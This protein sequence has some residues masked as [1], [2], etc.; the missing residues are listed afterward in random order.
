M[1]CTHSTICANRFIVYLHT[2]I[3]YPC[4]TH[5][6]IEWA[7]WIVFCSMCSFDN[8]SCLYIMY[9]SVC[10]L[11]SINMY[12]I[13]FI[14]NVVNKCVWCGASVWMCVCVCVF[15]VPFVNSTM[16]GKIVVSYVMWIAFR[17]LI[18]NIA[19]FVWLCM[20]I[21]VYVNPMRIEQ[22]CSLLCIW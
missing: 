5:W 19:Y 22:F 4:T 21:S 20:C 10:V 16:I 6:S 12:N 14:Q 9:S 11:C 15:E 13:S 7:V 8:W 17:R 1:N 18:A 2:T 3:H